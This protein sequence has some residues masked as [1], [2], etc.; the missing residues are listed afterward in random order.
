MK[1]KHFIL[2][3][4]LSLMFANLSCGG[5]GSGDYETE[6]PTRGDPQKLAEALTSREQE[7][8]PPLTMLQAYQIAQAKATEWNEDSY[9]GSM[10]ASTTD[11]LTFYFSFTAPNP[12]Y[13]S[14]CLRYVE[15]QYPEMDLAIE[16]ER[17]SGDIVYF[18]EGYINIYRG[19]LDP[20]PWLIDSP[21]ALEIANANGGA[22][23]RDSYPDCQ[24]GFGADGVDKCWVISYREAFSPG[25][26]GALLQIHVDPYTGE[27][28]IT[29]NTT[30]KSI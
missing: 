17:T 25:E 14:G 19:R 2:L 22:A 21:Q 28:K 7:D 4:T 6:P 26:V 15:K 30:G 16:I 11:D 18:S 29:E 20:N 10:S 3:L 24:I 8:P 12:S 5:N 27:A 23:F 9:L 1:T 13:G